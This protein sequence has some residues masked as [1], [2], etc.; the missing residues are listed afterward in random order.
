MRSMCSV[1]GGFWPLGI[2]QHPL[3]VVLPQEALKHND[4]KSSKLIKR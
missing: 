3:P 1:Q 2:L 4:V